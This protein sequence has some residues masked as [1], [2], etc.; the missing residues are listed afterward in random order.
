M[1][2]ADVFGELFADGQVFQVYRSSAL[3]VDHHEIDGGESGDQLG[4]SLDR[5]QGPGGILNHD[6]KKR[7]R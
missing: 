6:R 1:T 3:G 4:A 2:A 5:K 7:I